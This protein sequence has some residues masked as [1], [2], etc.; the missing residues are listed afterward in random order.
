MNLCYKKVAENL[1]KVLGVAKW[2]ICPSDA[3]L[4]TVEEWPFWRGD[5]LGSEVS[6]W[7]VL[8][9]VALTS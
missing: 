6:K 7:R 3:L 8:L 5:A 2:R 4:G 9:T 1:A